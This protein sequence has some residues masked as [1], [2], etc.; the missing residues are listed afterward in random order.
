MAR[1]L[2]K[3]ILPKLIIVEGFWGAGKT[4]FVKS[5]SDFIDCKVI[6]EPKHLINEIKSNISQWYFKKH[7]RNFA[8]AMFFVK[9]KRTVVMERSLISNFSYHYAATGKLLSGK[10][11]LREISETPEIVIVFLYSSNFLA[12]KHKWKIKDQTVTNSCEDFGTFIKRYIE[13]YMEILPKMLDAKI[14]SIKNNIGK[15]KKK[16]NAVIEE[17]LNALPDKNKIYSECVSAVI[18]ANDKI[19]LLYD[20]NYNHFVL[21][22]G[23]IE[24]GESKKNALLREIAEETGFVE[25]KIVKKVKTYQYNYING[26]DIVYK[27]IHVYLVELMG[28]KKIKKKL[29]RHEKYANHFFELRD[30]IKYARW[31]QDKQIIKKIQKLKAPC[32]HVT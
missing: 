15:Y 21:P 1:L 16:N 28:R 8:R 31:L 17:F 23:H 7:S 30:A 29:E 4:T 2:K 6:K 27:K 12:L 13:F 10:R 11:I 25:V 20:K 24:S 19:L 26:F 3:K 14:I 5:F 9:K 22:Q 32:R 18:T